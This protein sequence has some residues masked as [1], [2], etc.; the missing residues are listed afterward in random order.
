MTAPQESIKTKK[1]KRSK[2]SLLV[3][4]FQDRIEVYK[5]FGNFLHAQKIIQNKGLTS[6][7]PLALEYLI[8]LIAKER[9]PNVIIPLFKKLKELEEQNILIPD[10]RPRKVK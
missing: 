8:E 9:D 3:R 7:L 10:R 2:E 4:P 1:P 6:L 5:R